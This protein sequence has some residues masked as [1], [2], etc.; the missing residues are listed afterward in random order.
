MALKRGVNSVIL[1]S[2]AVVLTL[3]LSACG[4]RGALE[5]P[6]ASTPAET[7]AVATPVPVVPYS[8]APGAGSA[9]QRPTEPSR[10]GFFLDALI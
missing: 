4:R 5:L 2:L 1:C 3:G 10:S 7:P 8:S 9:V 6:V